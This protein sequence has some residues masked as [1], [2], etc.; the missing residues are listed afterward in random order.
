MSPNKSNGSKEPDK[1][2]LKE[3]YDQL[4]TTIFTSVRRRNRED[5]GFLI[6]IGMALV[7]VAIVFIYFFLSRLD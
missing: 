4:K 3:F 7:T 1:K 2:E 5:T 6:F